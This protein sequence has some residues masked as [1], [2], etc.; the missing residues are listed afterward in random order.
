M[1][2]PKTLAAKAFLEQSGFKHAVFTGDEKKPEAPMVVPNKMF[3]T[4][5]LSMTHHTAPGVPAPY[6]PP[7]RP[8]ATLWEQL[9][10]PS[11]K[12]VNED[13][14][15]CAA[16]VWKEEAHRISEMRLTADYSDD[17]NARRREMAEAAEFEQRIKATLLPMVKEA[18]GLPEDATSPAVRDYAANYA[19]PSTYAVDTLPKDNFHASLLSRATHP[20]WRGLIKAW[21][22]AHPEEWTSMVN[23]QGRWPQ[24][25]FPVGANSRFLLRSGLEAFEQLRVEV[26]H[27]LL[28]DRVSLT[29]LQ[30]PLMGHAL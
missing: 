1:T 19:T 25:G 12:S 16:A 18:L 29:T 3:N 21:C 7:P 2:N 4:G 9:L 30:K 27:D 17:G 22:K 23:L 20:S 6:A 24:Q 28:S 5:P 8:P 26:E 11:V 15:A 14:R 10:D 13:L